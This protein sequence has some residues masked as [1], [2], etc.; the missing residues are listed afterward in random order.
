MNSKYVYLP[1]LWSLVPHTET[2]IDFS[3]L[4]LHNM[5]KKAM[6]TSDTYK[7]G[8][9]WED[10]VAYVLQTIPE[11]KITGRRTRTKSQEIDISMAN[12]SL[13]DALWKLGAFILV[14][15]KNWHSRTNLPQIRNI[16]H[17]SNMKGNKTVILFS[18]EGVTKNA[19]EE[20]N[21]LLSEGLSIICVTAADLLQIQKA[22]DCKNLILSHWKELQNALHIHL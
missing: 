2:Q 20:I 3:P 8:A 17:I 16:A 14:E 19:E 18:A 5:I 22:S 9:L 6:N 21:R 1:Y 10:A 15:C 12:F 7:K 11:W 4:I 13:D